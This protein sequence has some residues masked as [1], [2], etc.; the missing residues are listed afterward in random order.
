MRIGMIGVVR[1]KCVL[2]GSGLFVAND[3]IYPGINNAN[4]ES[5]RPSMHILGDVHSERRVPDDTDWLAVNRNPGK[6]L[7][8]PKVKFNSVPRIKPRA[9]NLDHLVITDRTGEV[10]HGGI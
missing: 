2:F 3:A 1:R 9:R 4:I 8:N 6:V 10:L 5:I 7:N